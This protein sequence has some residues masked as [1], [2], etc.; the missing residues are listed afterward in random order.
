MLVKYHHVLSGCG[1]SGRRCPDLYSIIVE[2][3]W[4][5]TTPK[6]GLPQLLPACKSCIRGCC[7]SLT[8]FIPAHW[9]IS[10]VANI[11]TK[12][13]STLML[14]SASLIM[15]THFNCTGMHPA[16]D[17]KWLSRLGL[18]QA[19]TVSFLGGKCFS[20]LWT[21]CNAP[22]E[23]PARWIEKTSPELVL[24]QTKCILNSWKNC[25]IDC[26]RHHL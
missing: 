1:V 12:A 16:V 13:R 5:V 2:T 17:L 25:N 4:V 21:Q 9:R 8:V 22:Y 3:L 20:T 23:L 14:D 7:F 18:I 26:D 11:W 15:K 10:A 6:R 19:S 24:C